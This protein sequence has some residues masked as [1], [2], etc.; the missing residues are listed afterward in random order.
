LLQ[1][2]CK[3]LKRENDEQE[4]KL[5]EAGERN[6]V[7]ESLLH[8]TTRKMEKSLKTNRMLLE[9]T[10]YLDKELEESNRVWIA[11]R[12]D[13]D[14]MEM[15]VKTHRTEL[16]DYELSLREINMAYPDLLKDGQNLAR[17][18]KDLIQSKAGN[19]QESH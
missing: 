4:R 7:L 14:T 6:S 19:L 17:R 11:T 18:V 15:W 8:T 3:S 12:R 9:K 10:V 1:N 13:F 5:Q 16:E 2:Q